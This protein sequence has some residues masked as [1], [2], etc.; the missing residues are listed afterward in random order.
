MYEHHINH[1]PKTYNGYTHTQ[2]R[3]KSKHNTEDS[4]QIRKSGDEW[5]KKKRITHVGS[6]RT[7]EDPGEGVAV[8]T[9]MVTTRGRQ[10]MGTP[11]GEWHGGTIR[12]LDSFLSAGETYFLATMQEKT[13]ASFLVQT[14]SEFS[15]CTNVLCKC[16]Y[17]YKIGLIL[18][19]WF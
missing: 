8:P 6:H 12:R 1:K 15:L 13:I 17:F 9:D 11:A 18:Y 7:V 4:H 10:G 2:N 3:K 19:I 5:A 14:F 16:L